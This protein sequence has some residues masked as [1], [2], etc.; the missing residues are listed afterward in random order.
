[1]RHHLGIRDGR[2]NRLL[3]CAASFGQ[4]IVTGVE[5]LAFLELVGQQV[6]AVR[7]LAVEA[8]QLL[9]FLTQRL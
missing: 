9:L 4:G 8:E 6:L 1:M 2:T 5:V 7:Q 3:R